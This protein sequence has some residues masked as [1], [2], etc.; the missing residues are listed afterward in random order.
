[1]RPS[2]RALAAMAA[3]ALPLHVAAACGTAETSGGAACVHG[4]SVCC[5]A[6][7]SC[8]CIARCLP[9]LTGWGPCLCSGDG[10]QAPTDAPSDAPGGS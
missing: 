5:G 4:T 7:G 9:D 10:G 3:V 6:D 2:A 1:M 8:D